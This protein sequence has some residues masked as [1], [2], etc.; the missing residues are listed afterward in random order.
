MSSKGQVT[1]AFLKYAVVSQAKF[2]TKIVAL[3]VDD[4]REYQSNELLS[5]C[6]ENGTVIETTDGYTPELNGTF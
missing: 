5:F 6:F 2:N 3:R 4:K 1:A